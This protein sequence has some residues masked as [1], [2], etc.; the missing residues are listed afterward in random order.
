M[1]REEKTPDAPGKAP[2]KARK[3]NRS[4]EGEG[5]DAIGSTDSDTPGRTTATQREQASRAARAEQP[6]TGNARDEVTEEE[7]G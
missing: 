6:T 7:E 1:A 2:G 3:K 5:E 4:I